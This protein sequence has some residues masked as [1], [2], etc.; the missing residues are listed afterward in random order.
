MNRLKSYLSAMQPALEREI[1]R[2]IKGLS[3]LVRPMAEHTL[4]AG[5]KRLRP[6]LCAIT[7]AALGSSREDVLKLGAALEF[8]H[9]ATL[10]HDDILDGAAT[11]RGVR[12]AHEEFGLRQSVLAGDVLLAL[13]NRL[14]AEFHIPPLMMSVSR[15]I[16]ETAS[17]E[18][19]E[20]ELLGSG[21]PDREEYMRV[22][23]GKTACLISA[24]CECGAILAEASPEMVQAAADY[25]LNLGIA[26]QLV[27]DALDYQA[28]EESTGKPLG[29][30]LREGKFTLPLLLFLDDQPEAERSSL[31]T[32]IS[33]GSL[34]AGEQKQVVERI[35][36]GGYAEQTRTE[37]SA[38]LRR[39]RT[40]LDPFPESPERDLLVE[41]LAYVEQRRR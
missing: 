2:H 26:F 10:V 9:S 21:R 34:P 5:G 33:G 11:R 17:G 36:R 14:V 35:G 39:A 4:A 24:A 25:G 7:A 32:A 13:A 6:M 15:A 20:I 23:T 38:F 3:S 31:C 12:A 37:A 40:A 41:A 18:I 1:F 28:E 27:D 19:R 16:M 29:G 30:D 8:L 22:V